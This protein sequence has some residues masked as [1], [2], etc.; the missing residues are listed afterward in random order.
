L[1]S[2][3]DVTTISPPPKI[4]DEKYMRNLSAPRAPSDFSISPWR[5]IE[6]LNDPV[7][8]KDCVHM[9]PHKKYSK[10][11]INIESQS[12]W[13]AGGLKTKTFNGRILKANLAQV[14]QK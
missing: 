6:R 5:V 3:E 2:P 4:P 8:G 10:S 14:M 11:S 13:S 12:C 7:H 1:F 9:N